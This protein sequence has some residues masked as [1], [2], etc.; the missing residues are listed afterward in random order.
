MKKSHG[1]TL[2][3]LMITVAIIGILASIAYPAYQDQIRKSRRTDAQ[4]ILMNIAG[5]QQQFL[6]DTKAYATT[7]AD[8]GVTVPTS[9]SS[10]YTVTVNNVVNSATAPSEFVATATPQGG[11]ATDKCGT[12][13]DAITVNHTG[14]KTPSTCW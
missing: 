14:A 9:V 11:Q 10:F 3:E 8:L 2:I 4:S 6:L 5:R 12:P 13:G 1:F 7:L